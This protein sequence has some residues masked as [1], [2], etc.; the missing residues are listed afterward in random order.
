MPRPTRMPPR[1][2][3]DRPKLQGFDRLHLGDNITVVYRGVIWNVIMEDTVVT[4]YSKRTSSLEPLYTL[5]HKELFVKM[6]GSA[7]D[8]LWSMQ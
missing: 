1:A 2:P 6:V 7:F 4:S 8:R 5:V 3:D